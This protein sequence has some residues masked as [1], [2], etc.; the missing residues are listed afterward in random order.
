M[1]THIFAN[2]LSFIG[3]AAFAASGAMAGVAKKA[4]LLGVIILAATTATGGGVLRD[5]LL[6]FIPPKV[7]LEPTY[8]FMAVAVALVLFSFAYFYY[9][10]YLKKEG[11]IDKANN[12]FDALGLGIF[13]ALGTQTAID[14]GYSENMFLSVMIGTLTGVGGGFLRDIMILRVPV[15]L[16][17]HFYATA[18]LL[19][20]MVFYLMHLL[21]IKYSYSLTISA[22]VTFLLRMFATRF[23]WNLPKIYL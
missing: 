9:D 19:G 3:V 12:I 23:H 17:K 15:I 18:A 7:F 4:D 21:S 2:V 22:L 13:V 16:R 6:G 11:F 8:F 1:Y 20:S 14:S 10:E 5:I